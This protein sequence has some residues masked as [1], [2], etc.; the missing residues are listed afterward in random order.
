M[1][2]KMQ[3]EMSTF[4]EIKQHTSICAINE[5]EDVEHRKSSED[6]WMKVALTNQDFLCIEGKTGMK[7]TTDK[8]FS[9]RA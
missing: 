7:T 9:T 6:V 3:K 1:A 2:V 8:L 5:K 4:N